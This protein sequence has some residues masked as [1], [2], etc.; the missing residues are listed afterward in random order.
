MTFGEEGRRKTEEEETLSYTCKLIVLVKHT[1]KLQDHLGQWPSPKSD[2]PVLASVELRAAADPFLAYYFS[3][4]W[5]YRS[6]KFAATCFHRAICF[7]PPPAFVIG[8][9]SERKDK[10]V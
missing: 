6:V 1:G 5:T 9:Q 4:H 10:F 7:Q 3:F 8:Y 2:N